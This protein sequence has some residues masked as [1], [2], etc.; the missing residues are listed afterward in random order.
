MQDQLGKDC[1]LWKG[2]HV[3]VGAECDHEVAADTTHYGLT[4]TPISHSPAALR[5]GS[6]REWLEKEVIFSLF[7]ALTSLIYYQ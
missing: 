4:T 5:V 2:S 6:R 7:L 3:G 1:N